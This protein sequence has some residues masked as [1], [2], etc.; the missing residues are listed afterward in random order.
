MTTEQTYNNCQYFK[1]QLCPNRENP[2]MRQLIS[3]TT[4]SVVKRVPFREDTLQLVNL[5][6]DTYCKACE[7]FNPILQV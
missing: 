4:H 1:K 2:L 5:I 7:K 3:E 6:N